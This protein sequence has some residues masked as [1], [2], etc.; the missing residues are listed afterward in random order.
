MN[1]I[2]KKWLDAIG[3]PQDD[4]FERSVTLLSRFEHPD[5]CA[6]VYLQANGAH[7]VQRVI[8]ALP[9]HADAPLPAVLV[10][11]YFPEAMLGVDPTGEK[12]LSKYDGVEM[13]LHLV[14][15]G[16]AVASAEAY[17]LTYAQSDKTYNDFSRWQDAGE[18]ILR[19]HPSWSGIGKLVADT[20]LLIDLLAADPRI[21]ADRI[22]IAGHSLGGKMA[23]YTGCLDVRVKAIL[24]SDFGFGWDQS[25]WNEVW[26]WGEKLPAIR[27]RGMDHTE[28]LSLAAPKPFCLLAGEYDDDTSGEMM[29]RANGYAPDDTRLKIVNHA[30]GHRPPAWALNEGYDFLDRALKPLGK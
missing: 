28:L 10:P 30:T 9:H 2:K 20:Q 13:M 22:G 5:F 4:V 26:Y 24:A 23:F 3:T 19:D 25:N 12:D 11:F 14:R 6:E 1:P 7:S 29:R 16:Y 17:H 21:D 8:L 27:A 15:R 18:A